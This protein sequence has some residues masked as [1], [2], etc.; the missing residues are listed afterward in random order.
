MCYP[1]VRIWAGIAHSVSDSAT[2]WTNEHSFDSLQEQEICLFSHTSR[3]AVGPFRAAVEWILLATCW[4]REEGSVHWPRSDPHLM[5]RLRMSGA[6]LPLPLVLLWN[7]Q[8]QLYRLYVSCVEYKSW[9]KPLEATVSAFHWCLVSLDCLPYT[10]WSLVSVDRLFYSRD[11]IKLP[12]LVIL[13][14][15]IQLI[16]LKNVDVECG[17]TCCQWDYLC[18]TQ[19]LW[20]LLS[21]GSEKDSSDSI[22]QR[23]KSGI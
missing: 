14:C 1:Y 7:A 21:Y 20:K 13:L 19:Y 9:V 11:P 22:R 17:G 3:P 10:D 16:P 5:S 18:C 8:E 23:R 6:I 2:G 12:Q 15:Q 4:G